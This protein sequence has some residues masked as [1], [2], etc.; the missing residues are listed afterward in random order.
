MNRLISTK[1]GVFISLVGLSE[2][3]KSQ[4]FYNWPNNGSFRQKFDKI[5]FFNQ[6]SQA[7]YDAMQKEIEILEFV[8][9]VNFEFIHSLKN[10][11]RKY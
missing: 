9:G 8:N 3:R 2:T 4:L 5:Y 1:N 6:H 11:G 7:L 10:N